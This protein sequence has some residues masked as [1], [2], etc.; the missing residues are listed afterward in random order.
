[1]VGSILFGIEIDE[2]Q[3]KDRESNY[4]FERYNDLYMGYSGRH[5]FIRISPFGSYTTKDGSR[6]NPEFE[7]RFEVA[8]EVI[9][10]KLEELC[11]E[12]TCSD[13]LLDVTTLFF[14]E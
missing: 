14:D 11:S 7:E 12:V 10:N 13:S 9:S 4:E 8:K 1:M 3:H 6:R 2:R 5:V